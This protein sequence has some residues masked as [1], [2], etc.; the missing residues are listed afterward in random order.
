VF[1]VSFLPDTPNAAGIYSSKAVGE[2]AILASASV[3]SAL[4][5]AVREVRREMGVTAHFDLSA[6]ATP[7]EVQRLCSLDWKQFG[8]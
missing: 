8:L 2:P 5:H 3:L 1:D 4:R 7:D 6:P